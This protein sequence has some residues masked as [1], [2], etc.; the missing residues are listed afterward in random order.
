MPIKNPSDYTFSLDD[1]GEVT[2]YK[3]AD[4]GF[5][6]MMFAIRDLFGRSNPKWMAC[7]M[8]VDATHS[9]LRDEP[10]LQR[11]FR[12]IDIFEGVL[13]A[14][15]TVPLRDGGEE[16][17]WTFNANEFL[18]VVEAIYASGKYRDTGEVWP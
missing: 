15:A 2:N 5:T 11:W 10:R 18:A 8:R 9:L 3:M 14:A 17:G 12:D 1:G 13:D 6:R 7:F 4:T 16:E